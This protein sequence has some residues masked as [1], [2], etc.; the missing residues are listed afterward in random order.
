MLKRTAMLLALACGIGC[1]DDV[2]PS[3]AGMPDSG[4]DSG[5]PDAGPPT[6]IEVSFGDGTV[7]GRTA[8]G[9]HSFLGIPYAAPPTGELRWKPP[10]AVTPWTTPRDASEVGAHCAQVNVLM[11]SDMLEG[12]EDCLFLNVFT[13]ELSPATPLPVFVFIHGGAF[14]LG[15]GGPNPRRLASVSSTVVVTMNYRLDELGFMAHSALT[16]E[17][18]GT[19]GNYG[20]LDQRAAL[21]WVR[22]NIAAFGGDASNVTLAG[23]SAGGI[24]VLLH[25]MSPGSAGLFHRAVVQSGA[26]DILEPRT[27]AAAE[28][29]GDATAAR[30]GCTDPANALACLRGKPVAELIGASDILTLPGGLLYQGGVPVP[31]PI[32]DGTVV[33]ERPVAA[34]AAG[35][36]EHVPFLVGSNA[37][38]GTLFQSSLLST[39]VA[40]EAE[41]REAVT[42]A[43]PASVDAIL[44]Q[45]PV[46]SYA[47]ANAALTAATSD[48]FSCATRRLVRATSAA[49]APTWL[50]S[51]EA[52]P[53]GAI[54]AALHLGA[55]HGAELIYLF[56]MNDPQLGRPPSADRALVGAMQG[57]WTR[58]AASGDPNGD[59]ATAWPSYD[60]ATDRHMTLVTPPV[61]GEAHRRTACDFW[62][63]VA[64]TM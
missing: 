33:P 37:A 43:S 58:F 25:G 13:P 6:E 28:S 31:S 52:V 54:V 35:R 44:T 10:A 49:G 53:A 40:N 16:T 17:G 3:D 19:S 15:S 48:F 8:G 7:I 47:D 27:L 23:E 21:E 30:V 55:Y 38:E 45:Y 59:A 29:A 57:Y 62:D 56:D 11:G 51:F 20:L 61:A 5:S 63:T 50:Y 42:R 32:V 1:G 24:S 12:D 64:A 4:L 18:G 60:T 36:F 26:A 2:N 22:D 14:V 41:Y 9:V 34:Y 46:A 39:P